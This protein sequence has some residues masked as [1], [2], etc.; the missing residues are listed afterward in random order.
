MRT[1]G[2]GMATVVE[3]KGATG[4]FAT[5][6]AVNMLSFLGLS[7]I[8]LQCDPEPSLIK[9]TESV[10]SKRSERVLP[11][12]HI[13]AME[14]LDTIRNSCMERCAQCWRQMQERTQYRP[15]ADSALIR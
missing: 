8:T 7:D 13:S 5:M 4:V 14:E 11:D 3:M 15:T 6:W 2:Y 1:F 9:W 12:G 10:K